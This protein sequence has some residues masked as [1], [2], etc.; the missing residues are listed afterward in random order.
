LAR[1][2][3]RGGPLDVRRDRLLEAG[4]DA[5]YRDARYYA[6]SYADREHDVRYYVAL[7]AA[8]GGPVLEYGCGNGRITLPIA[9]AGVRVIGVDRSPSMLA[10][11]RARLAAE[12]R[13]VRQRTR[14]RAGDMRAL[15]LGARFPLVLCTFNTFL[16]LYA[17]RDV[18]RFLARVRG[19]LARGGRFVFDA[20]V[21]DPDELRC[22][23]RRAY[24][25]PPF[26]HA[27]AG[28]VVRYGERFDYDALCQVLLVHMEFEPK[29]GGRAW[30]TPLAHRQFFP[31]ELE[32][33]L[34]YNGFAV[35]ELHGD[36]ER[37]RARPDDL[38]L[39]FHC[40]AR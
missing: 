5:H 27:S 22:D 10:D 31:Q 6:A 38:A 39:V 4:S 14:V 17:R 15:A 34:H 8:H 37:R 29:N 23:P 20:S 26:R 19:H 16:H 1:R 7:A 32:A 11:L 12:P 30:S 13:L 28:C 2:L 24:R 9:R 36:F 3:D 25:T 21:P 18:E 35:R 33:L 40:T